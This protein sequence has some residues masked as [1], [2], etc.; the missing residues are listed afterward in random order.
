MST[1]PS[2]EFSTD[3]K[4]DPQQQGQTSAANKP[5][6]SSKASGEVLRMHLVLKNS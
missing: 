1:A 3:K 5:K 6:S 2:N 4:P